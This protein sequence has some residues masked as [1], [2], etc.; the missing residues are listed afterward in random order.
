[1]FADKNGIVHELDADSGDEIFCFQMIDY[2]RQN[3][4]SKRTLLVL[5]PLILIS[6]YFLVPFMVNDLGPMPVSA[7]LMLAVLVIVA[8]VMLGNLIVL[9][10]LGIVLRIFNFSSSRREKIVFGGDAFKSFLYGTVSCSDIDSYEI[11]TFRYE[12]RIDINTHDFRIRYV[13]NHKPLEEFKALEDRFER[14]FS[15]YK[16]AETDRHI[17]RKNFFK[18]GFAKILAGLGALVIVAGIV[19]MPVTGHVIPGVFMAIPAVF[20][21]WVAIYRA[22]QKR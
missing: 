8:T 2:R 6:N 13:L 12:Q 16:H 15:E 11:S 1:M 3:K 17:E 19:V 5:T 18:T 22:Q 14:M 20:M 9:L 7:A 10:L 4:I 21:L